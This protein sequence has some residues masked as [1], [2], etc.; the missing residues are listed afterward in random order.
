[1]VFSLCRVLTPSARF[2]WAPRL[3][4]SSS[5]RAFHVFSYPLGAVTEHNG[6]E[7]LTVA[8]RRRAD[9]QVCWP[10]TALGKLYDKRK[11][12]P[13]NYDFVLPSEHKAHARGSATPDA[14]VDP[15][16]GVP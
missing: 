12:T 16:R 2:V 10:A 1:M 3:L 4:N 6:A 5:D 13:I 14:L 8:E 11:T 15:C 7:P 9:R